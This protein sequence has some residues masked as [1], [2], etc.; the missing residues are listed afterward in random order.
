MQKGQG[1]MEYLLLLGGVAVMVVIATV[2]ILGIIGDSDNE[3]GFTFDIFQIVGDKYNVNLVP[4]GNFEAGDDGTWALTGCGEIIEDSALARGGVKLARANSC[5][6]GAPLYFVEQ[7][8]SNWVQEAGTYELC[9]SAR[10]SGNPGNPVDMLLNL[11]GSISPPIRLEVVDTTYERYCQEA[12]LTPGN[13]YIGIG[14]YYNDAYLD[15]VTLRR[16]N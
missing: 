4:N 1:S 3:V 6:F 2:I 14:M 9:V 15:D 11:D 16:I 10:H 13:T 8:L 7:T 12:N 5:A